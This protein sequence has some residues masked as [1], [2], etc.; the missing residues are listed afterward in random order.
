M[1]ASPFKHN[2]L[3]S[4]VDPDARGW[5][6][7]GRSWLSPLGLPEVKPQCMGALPSSYF[8]SG[9]CDPGPY[10]KPLLPR[11]LLIYFDQPNSF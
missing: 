5:E 8:F 2:K 1:K 3:G 4:Q 6:G 9:F 7:K 11:F 10:I